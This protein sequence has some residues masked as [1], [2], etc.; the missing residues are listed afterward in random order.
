[1]LILNRKTTTR[2][3][4]QI[5]NTDLSVIV[6]QTPEG[7]EIRVQILEVKNGGVAVGLTAPKDFKI[8]RQEILRGRNSHSS[9]TADRTA[10]GIL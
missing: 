10:E 9:G 6:I 2:N 4:L 3:G 5:D 1:M 8:H 7:E